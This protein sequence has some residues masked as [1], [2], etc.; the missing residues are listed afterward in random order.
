MGE[1]KYQLDSTEY[2]LMVLEML[3]DLHAKQDSLA[4]TVFDF[5]SAV[6]KTDQQEI[7]AGFQERTGLVRQSVVNRLYESYG[8][9]PDSVKEWLKDK[10]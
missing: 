10:E 9:L 1:D 4:L 6:T 5:L 8:Q 3:I 7:I 2:P